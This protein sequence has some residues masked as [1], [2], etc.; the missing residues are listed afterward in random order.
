[1]RYILVTLVV[2]QRLTSAL[3]VD[4]ALNASRIEVT[5]VT[6][7]P[8]MAPNSL[9]EH[10]PS[11]GFELKHAVMAQ[12]KASSVMNLWVQHEGGPSTDALLSVCLNS[13]SHAVAP[14]NMLKEDTS[15]GVDH[16]V[17]SAL[18]VVLPLNA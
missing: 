1:M 18:N 7:H 6:S 4:L 13:A 15:F 16:P 8:G 9:D 5:R 10:I 2:F 14:E 12:L 17:I 3:N 11:T